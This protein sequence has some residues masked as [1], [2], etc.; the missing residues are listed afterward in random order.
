MGGRR[1]GGRERGRPEG[2]AVGV[3]PARRWTGG[4]WRTTREGKLKRA[5][6]VVGDPE[7]SSPATLG[8]SARPCP[9]PRPPRGAKAPEGLGLF[10][11]HGGVWRWA[12]GAEMCTR[13]RTQPWTHRGNSVKV[14]PK[15]D[16]VWTRVSASEKRSPQGRAFQGV[17]TRGWSRPQD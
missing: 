3:A 13:V 15:S 14:D 17:G 2:R 16:P 4:T 5:V 12:P 8:L 6:G 11:T 7:A 10:R 1:G 9:R